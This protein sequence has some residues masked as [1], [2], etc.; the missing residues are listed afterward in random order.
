MLVVVPALLVPIVRG[1]VSMSTKGGDKHSTHVGLQ[2]GATAFIAVCRVLGIVYQFGRRFVPRSE[3]RANDD[4]R[5]STHAGTRLGHTRQVG[6]RGGAGPRGP[7]RPPNQ[8]DHSPNTIPERPSALWGR[9]K[10]LDRPPPASHL[11]SPDALFHL[12]IN[13]QTESPEPRGRWRRSGPRCCWRRPPCWPVAALH[14]SCPPTRRR[15]PL[16]WTAGA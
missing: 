3:R 14:S 7:I 13:T 9:R 6:C 10:E 15:P 5:R 1:Q 12:Y 16:A 8:V 2:R 4:R 11:T